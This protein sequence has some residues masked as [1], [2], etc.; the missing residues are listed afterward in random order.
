MEKSERLIERE[1]LIGEIVARFV[2]HLKREGSIEEATERCIEEAGDL[3]DERAETFL[4]WLGICEAQWQYGESEERSREALG[5]LVSLGHG[6]GT[7]QNI[8][9]DEVL[10]NRALLESTLLRLTSPNPEPRPWP[11]TTVRPPVYRAG[12]CLSIALPQGRYGA[13][14]VLSE[15]NSDPEQGLNLIGVLNYLEESPPDACVFE[16]REWLWLTHRNWNNEQD[17]AWY[18]PLGHEE[19]KERFVAVGETAV[20]EDDPETSRIIVGWS[21]LGQ[22]VLFEREWREHGGQLPKK[23]LPPLDFL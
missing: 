12:Q 8:S 15:D 10:E 14:I 23:E 20:R 22:Q 9:P 4:F 16:A 6:L 17:V 2:H 3:M 21:H 1:G 19:K 13:A 11:R 5:R 18:G 7:R